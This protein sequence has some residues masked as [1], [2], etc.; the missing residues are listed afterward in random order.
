MFYHM[1][2]VMQTC[3]AKVKHILVSEFDW[4]LMPQRGQVKSL[5]NKIWVADFV[6]AFDSVFWRTTVK[7]WIWPLCL[8]AKLHGWVVSSHQVL[9]EGMIVWSTGA[10]YL[11]FPRKLWLLTASAFVPFLCKPA[12]ILKLVQ[13][14]LRNMILVTWW[15]MIFMRKTFRANP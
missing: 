11:M 5:V 14:Y 4:R 3:K 8:L 15:N 9:S 7:K 2:V 1:E 10:Q 12:L 6:L 13:D